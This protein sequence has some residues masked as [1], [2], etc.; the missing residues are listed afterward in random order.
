MIDFPEPVIKVAV[1]PKT[2]ADQQKMSVALA[3]LAEEDPT[4]QVQTNEET[5]Q[6]EISG[7]GEL[8]LEVLVDRMLRE[9]KVDAN[10]GRPQVSYRETVRGTAEKIEGRFVRQT[11]GS[12][13]YGIVYINL[14]PAPGEGFDFVNKV[15]GGNVPSEFIPAVEKGIEEALESGVKAGYPMVDVRATLTDGKIGRASCRE[16]V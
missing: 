15:K 12:G 6:T 14:E 8:H 11:G 1:E 7:M 2:K 5:G 13:Q 10:V 4:F 3:R 16:R 9:Y